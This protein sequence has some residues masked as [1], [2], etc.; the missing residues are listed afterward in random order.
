MLRISIDDQ[1]YINYRFTPWDSKIFEC[2][3]SE[4]LEIYYNN[5]ANLTL[6]LI[7]FEKEMDRNKISFTYIRINSNDKLLKVLLQKSG[8]YFVETSLSVSLN[9]LRKH[10]FKS[11]FRNDLKLIKPDEIDFIQIKSI[12]QNAFNYGRFHEDLYID[13]NKAKERYF[14]WIDDLRKQSKNFLVYKVENEII[15][16]LIYELINNNTVELIL[17]GS[18]VNRGLMSPYFWSS[19]MTYF[20]ENEIKKVKTIISSSNLPILNL[21]NKFNFTV[22]ETMFGFHKFR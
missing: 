11:I 21:Y 19:F 13:E 6:L 4:I 1:N 2:G 7:D 9:N 3:T 5:E 16:F 14:N 20:Q 8:Y 15:S 22:E 17:A 18:N 12:A 10:N